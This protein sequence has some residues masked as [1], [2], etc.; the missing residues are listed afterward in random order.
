GG[1][2]EVLSRRQEVHRWRSPFDRRHTAC[3]DVGIPRRDRLR[4]AGLG[5]EVRRRH[6][7][8]ARQ[9]LQRAGGRRAWLHCM[10]KDAIVGIPDNRSKGGVTMSASSFF[11]GGIWMLNLL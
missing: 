1:I 3:R 4:A 5:Q 6:G 7:G 9:G 8:E 10:G 11:T 2:R